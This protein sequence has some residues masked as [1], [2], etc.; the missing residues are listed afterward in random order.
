M[1]ITAFISST[2][3]AINHKLL[4]YEQ[5]KVCTDNGRKP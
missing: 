5:N 2:E 4:Y 3:D 1:D